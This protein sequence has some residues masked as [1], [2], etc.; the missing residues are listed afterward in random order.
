MAKGFKNYYNFIRTHNG[1]DKT[2]AQASGIELQLGRNKW[3]GLLKMSLK[4][5]K[6]RHLTNKN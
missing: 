4:N 1:I 5:D 3:L 6:T 2:P